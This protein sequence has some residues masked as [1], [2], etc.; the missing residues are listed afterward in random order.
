MSSAQ[1]KADGEIVANV[2]TASSHQ[3]R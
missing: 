1:Q 2:A 3:Q